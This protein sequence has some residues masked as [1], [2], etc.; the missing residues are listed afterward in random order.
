MFV[1]NYRNNYIFTKGNRYI[2]MRKDQIEQSGK[3]HPPWRT[4]QLTLN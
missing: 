3:M 4:P 2:A 1:F